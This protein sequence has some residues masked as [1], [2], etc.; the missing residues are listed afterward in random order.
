VL[1]IFDMDGTLVAK[2]KD[3][4]PTAMTLLPGVGETCQSLVE[5]G[6]ILGIA[7][8]QG[9]VAFGFLTLEEAEKRVKWVAGLI[10]A[11]FYELCPYHPD[12]IVM[13]YADNAHCRKPNPGMLETLQSRTG[14]PWSEI[15]MVGDEY[16]DFQAAMN[17]G[18]KFVW[19]SDFF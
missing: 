8:N 15:V 4:R 2:T 9:G 7:S 6:N 14:V 5:G 10:G 18:V 19:A 1:Y 12:G 16:T 13:P 11:Q 17:A 3:M